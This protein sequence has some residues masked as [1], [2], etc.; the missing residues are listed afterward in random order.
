MSLSPP[1]YEALIVAMTLAPGVYA[2]NRMFSFY[3]KNDGKKARARASMLRG[4]VRHLGRAE[5]LSVVSDPE[6]NETRFVLRYDLP[7]M[8]LSRVAELSRIELAALRVL[9]ERASAR[10]LSACP[11]DVRLVDEALTQLLHVGDDA[12]RPIEPPV[13]VSQH[14]TELRAQS[15]P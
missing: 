15:R 9:A 13:D 3:E 7:S 8:C 6:S 10:H 5:A 2:R 14:D 1:A 11:E 12:S 4:I